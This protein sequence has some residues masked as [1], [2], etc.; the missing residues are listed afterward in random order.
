MPS[1][2]RASRRAACVVTDRQAALDLL[3]QPTQATAPMGPRMADAESSTLLKAN[4]IPCVPAVYKNCVRS[5]I[6]F[7]AGQQRPDRQ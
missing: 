1:R 4:S 7:T 2:L 5:T 6:E 3:A